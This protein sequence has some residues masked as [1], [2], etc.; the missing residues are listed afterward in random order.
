MR[1]TWLTVLGAVAA[2][3]VVESAVTQ[4]K[5]QAKPVAD[6]KPRPKADA[7]LI[8]RGE[9]LVNEVGK[10]G[11][12]H[13]PRTPRGGLDM[14]KH[15]QGAEIWF[16]PKVKPKEWEGEAPDITAAGVTG[17]WGEAKMIKFLTTGKNDEGEAPDAP[18]PAY[19]L[20]KD[21]ATAVTAYLMSLKG[22]AEKKPEKKKD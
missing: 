12:C 22:G 13:T 19:K 7:A 2:C 8:K 1:Y 15:L 4:E 11:E 3:V 17:K 14:S 21:D 18:M 5:R 10:C 20:S 16:T 9:Y 6:E